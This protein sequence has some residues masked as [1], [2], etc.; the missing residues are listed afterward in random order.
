MCVH[1][2]V[3]EGTGGAPGL[4][5]LIDPILLLL[6]LVLLLLLLVPVLGTSSGCWV[7]SVALSLILDYCCTHSPLWHLA[8]VFF[9]KFFFFVVVCVRVVAVVLAM[10]VNLSA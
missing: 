5:H 2:C 6:L 1:A 8:V 9:F 3:R 10:I 4:F 7:F